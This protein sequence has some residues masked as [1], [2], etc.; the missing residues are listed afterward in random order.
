MPILEDFLF[1]IDGDQMTITA[2]NLET[3]I[4]TS[5]Q[6]SSK[7]KGACT[8]PAKILIDTLKALP[9]QPL[10]FH[11]N[12]DNFAVK[13]T[14]SFGTYKLSG[15]DPSEYPTIPSDDNT[16]KLNI[17]AEALKIALSRTSFA[18]S[19]DELRQAMMGVYFD[20]DEGKITFV[21]TDAH[22]LVRYTLRGL[23][24][25]KAGSFIVPKKSLGLLNGALLNEGDVEVSYNAKNVFFRYD[26]TSVIC[27]LIDARYPDY[28]AVIPSENPL[29]LIAKRTDLLQS[30]KRLAI[31]ANKST[32]QVIFNMQ[33]D[34]L[35][36]S[37][38]DLDFSNEAKEQLVCTFN[39]D[40]LTM[41]FNAKFFI[42]MLNIL[43]TEEIHFH[44]SEPNRAGV[45]VPS[46]NS[47]EEELL[48]LVMPVMMGY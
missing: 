9:E 40:P 26:D 27:R 32:N 46:N 36:I 48:M 28:N 11:V 35:T 44:L 4:I 30:L 12:D 15:G 47:D 19:N 21:A 18:T 29:E 23:D 13:I 5:A 42:E 1:D 2:S 31:Y 33:E 20:I 34:G 25:K 38:Q 45:L 10:K 22:K 17:S 3:T 39:G 8:M 41:G 43:E 7:D 16:E 37:S 6:P 14:S 24:A